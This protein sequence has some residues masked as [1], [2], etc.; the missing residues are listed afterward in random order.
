MDFKLYVLEKTVKWLVGGDLL[1]FIQKE[2]EAVNNENLTGEEKRRLVIKEAK[3]FF[4][5]AGTF[6]INLAIE[7]A[8]LILKAQ[9]GEYD[10]KVIPQKGA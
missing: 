5:G 2:V 7:V 4:T 1:A 3:K 9:I 10:D 8:V 6:L